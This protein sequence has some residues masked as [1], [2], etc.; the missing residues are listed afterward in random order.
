MPSVYDTYGKLQDGWRIKV[1]TGG[2]ET[3]LGRERLT[4]VLYVSLKLAGIVASGGW[5]KPS[6]MCIVPVALVVAREDMRLTE[7]G[8]GE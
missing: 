5:T 6:L 8:Y 4:S 2:P 3:R 7:K 1:H